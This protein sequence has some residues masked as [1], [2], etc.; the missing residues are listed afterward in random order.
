M[1]IPQV[2]ELMEGGDLRKALW[3]NREEYAW[4]KRG[5]QVRFC[6]GSVENR[7]SS[8]RL[9]TL[10]LLDDTQEQDAHAQVA[11]DVARGLHFLHSSGVIHRCSRWE[12]SQ[13][14]V[15]CHANM[16][17]PL[18][19]SSCGSSMVFILHGCT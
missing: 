8:S 12:L 6:S 16:L 11:L 1:S 13:L 5:A 4:D 15:V 10:N 18:N 17:L 3:Q 9:E 7:L 2:M 14:C 19:L